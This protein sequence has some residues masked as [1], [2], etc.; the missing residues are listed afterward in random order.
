MRVRKTAVWLLCIAFVLTALT[1]CGGKG[2]SNGD[3]TI[4]YGLSAEPKTLDPQIASDPPSL[5]AI[6]GL[7]EGLARLDADGNAYPGAAERWRA[8][9]D[10]TE[11]TFSLRADAKWSDKTPVTAG[12]FVYAFRRAL[13][14]Q[15]AS[16]TCSRMFCL[17]NAR[18]VNAG[19]LSPDRL[20]VE[21]KDAHT[22]VVRLEY[23]YP[24]FPAL[25]A[26]AV[27]MPCNQAFFEKTAGRYG[28]EPECVLGNGPFQIDGKYGWAHDQYL[29]LRRSATYSGERKPL[30]SNVD[31]NIDG[32]GKVDLS[33]PIAALQSGTVDAASVPAQ[34]T[35]AAA[36]AG[37][38]IVSFQNTTW[39][40]CFNAS[41]PLM[42]NADVRRAFVQAFD[43]SRV[44]SHLPANTSKAENIL[45]PGTT[46]VGENY[47]KLAGGPFYLPHDANAAQT[48]AKGLGELGRSEMDSVS[49]LCPDD[50]NV[51]LMLNEMIIAWNSQFHNYFNLE[52]LPEGNLLSRVKSGDY[53][54]A[55]Y[56]LR[57]ESDGPLSALS[58]FRSGAAGNPAHLSDAGYDAILNRAESGDGKAAAADYAEAEK[59][60]NRQAVF[61][62]LY[63]EKQSYAMAKGVTGI[64]FH[65]YQG[66]VDFIGAGKE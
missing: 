34:K 62:P 10:Q 47:R 18:Q 58:P 24:D 44:L 52:S 56:P 54:V 5:T 28:L 55:F 13:S 21:A 16:P 53:Q 7:F 57:P 32:G 3:K 40:L 45:L 8:N 2:P 29:N 17:K 14:P 12:D 66:G 42:K 65:P 61:Y 6:Q 30:P 50:L 31:L 48:L 1:A 49:V 25:T 22:L 38:T 23:P 43:R 4:E 51:K 64:V 19:S 36:A 60:L 41:S 46:F 33:D 35:E 15:T 27:F 26:V 9:P 63:Y 59:Y 11:F 20:G 39:G 37:C